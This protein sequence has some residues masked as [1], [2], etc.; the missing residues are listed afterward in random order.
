MDL[1]Q[2]F[3]DKWFVIGVI[4]LLSVIGYLAWSEFSK[5]PE[6]LKG[7]YLEGL[8]A[9]ESNRLEDAVLSLKIVYSEDPDYES[10]RYMLG[11]S[12]FYLNDFKN[13][14][15]LFGED[16]AENS[17]RTNSGIWWL[18]TRFV[19]G[20]DSEELLTELEKILKKD[21]EK[22][23]A[24]ILKGLLYEKKGK[25]WDAIQSYQRASEGLNRM[26]FV[27]DRLSK[28][29]T[30]NRVAQ[31]AEK[32]SEIAKVLGYTKPKE[33]KTSDIVK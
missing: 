7:N 3:K 30:K 15:R 4:T 33:S 11:K 28:L 5:D 12:Y 24:W 19:L 26:G 21:P 13:A 14:E 29:Y 22:T 10:V 9:F 27:S 20:Q 8:A 16:Y 32:Y 6:K 23:E 25:P 18:R 2:E 1:R 17:W 31:K